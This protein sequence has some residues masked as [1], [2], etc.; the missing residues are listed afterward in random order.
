[1]QLRS[2]LCHLLMVILFLGIAGSAFAQKHV[3]DEEYRVY[4]AALGSLESIP[5][6]DPHVVIYDRTLT[7]K[8]DTDGENPVLANG[9]TFLWVRPDTA[10]DVEQLLR[11]RWHGLSKSTWKDFLARNA[12]SIA[13]HDPIVTPWKHRLTGS[14]MPE[15]ASK[16]W[17]SP[18]LTIFF[19]R[20]GFNSHKTEA[21]VYVLVFSYVKQVATTGDYLRFHMD[22][23]KKWQLVGRVNYFAGQHKL[24]AR[25]SVGPPGR[26]PVA[27]S[28]QL[29]E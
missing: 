2:R 17:A 29:P 3:S 4:E 28:R 18:D 8:C 6:T 11:A 12:K 10:A 20:V 9:C 15:D 27:D 5:K 25:L 1:M 16:E 22:R 21:I 26:G 13:L 23:Y 7:S 24:L 19:S 14:Q